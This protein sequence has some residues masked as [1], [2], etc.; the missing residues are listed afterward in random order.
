MVV[1]R[2]RVPVSNL[3]D[4]IKTVVGVNLRKRVSTLVQKI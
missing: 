3:S 1:E 2:E 4:P